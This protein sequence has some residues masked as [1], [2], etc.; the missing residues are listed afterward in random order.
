MSDSNTYPYSNYILSPEKLGSSS[1]PKA[2]GNN[3]KALA[4]YVQVLVSGQ[5]KAQKVSPLGN[6]YFMDTG[7]KCKD[8]T[9]AEQTRY[10]YINNVPDGNIPFISSA[11]G[12]TMSSF[13][14][15]VPGVLGNIA[16]INPAKLF[17]AFSPETPCQKIKMP[18]RDISNNTT[19]EEKYVNESDIKEYNPC[20]FS[21]TQ[22]SKN[23]SKKINPVTNVECAEGMTTRTIH[24][25]KMVQVYT[26]SIYLLGAY[27]LFRLV[28]K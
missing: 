2:L 19:E 22:V 28:Q 24:D 18:I 6:K 13:E 4:A 17:S 14:G 7:G 20:W 26:A 23:K 27:I 12:E 1:N 9:G 25:D 5:S 21:T 8:S 15:L 10:V 16:Y 3:V 11:M